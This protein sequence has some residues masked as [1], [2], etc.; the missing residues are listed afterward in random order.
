MWHLRNLSVDGTTPTSLSMLSSRVP[1]RGPLFVTPEL[2]GRLSITCTSFSVEACVHVP[3]DESLPAAGIRERFSAAL[4]WPMRMLEAGLPSARCLREF[5]LMW[6][7]GDLSA[8]SEQL[9]SGMH[10]RTMFVYLRS[11]LCNA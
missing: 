11:A 4:G 6:Y 10:P 5:H 7:L 2:S 9:Q 3:V 8:D 1:L